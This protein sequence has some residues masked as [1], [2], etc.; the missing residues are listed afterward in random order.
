MND[1]L[2]DVQKKADHI[3]HQAEVNKKKPFKELK[4]LAISAS[5]EQFKTFIEPNLI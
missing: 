4:E 3:I 2:K 5:E 1:F